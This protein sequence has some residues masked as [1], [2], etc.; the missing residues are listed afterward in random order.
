MMHRFLL[1]LVLVS[2]MAIGCNKDDES[3]PTAATTPTYF[4]LQ[5]D[6][7]ANGAEADTTISIYFCVSNCPPIPSL[8]V[9]GVSTENIP[10]GVDGDLANVWFEI[11][12]SPAIQFVLDS[13]GRATSGTLAMPSPPYDV[14]CNGISLSEN[15]ATAIPDAANYIFQWEC[16]SFDYFAWSLDW[17]TTYTTLA[18]SCSTS[19]LNSSNDGYDTYWSLVACRGARMMPGEQPNVMGDYGQGYA[20]ATYGDYYG[21]HSSNPTATLTGSRTESDAPEP[22]S[23]DVFLRRFR[24]CVGRLEE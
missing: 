15:Q 7:Y 8:V 23:Q 1:A 4:A 3:P 6:W 22:N 14:S 20:W 13:R 10:W 17:A 12:Y 18:Q 2:A 24:D 11:P 9:N 19:V 21:L 5:A 16:E